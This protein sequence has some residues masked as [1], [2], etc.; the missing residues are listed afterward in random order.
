MTTS[1]YRRERLASKRTV[2]VLIRLTQ[3]CIEGRVYAT[4]CIVDDNKCSAVIAALA[5]VLSS[6]FT[7]DYVNLCRSY[8]DICRC[9][10]TTASTV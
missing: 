7:V 2:K 10:S 8:S 3:S 4:W 6:R 1:M 9:L 5:I